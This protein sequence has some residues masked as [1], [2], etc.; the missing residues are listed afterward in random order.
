VPVGSSSATFSILV[1]NVPAT[2]TLDVIAAYDDAVLRAP[3]TI[4]G[5][6]ASLASMTVNV[7]TLTGGQGGVGFVNLTAPAPAGHV[8]V[9]LSTD[10]PS[11]TLPPNV[12]IS[13]GSTNGLFSFGALPVDVVTPV[14]I[15]ATYGASRA[16]AGVTINP[17]TNVWVT[18]LALSPTTVTGGSSSTGTVTINAPA[19]SGG[20]TVQ[21][22]PWSPGHRAR[23]GNR[24][25]RFHDRHLHDWHD[26]RDVDDAGQDMGRSQHVVG[27]GADDHAWSGKRAVALHAVAVAHDRH[28]RQ[29]V[30]GHGD[31]ERSGAIRWLGRHALEQQYRRCDGSGERDGRGGNVESNLTVTTT[32]VS[33]QA[34]ATITGSLGVSRSSTLTINPST[35]TPAAPALVAPADGATVTLPVTLDWSDVAN[36]VS[37]QIQVDDSSAFTS[38]FVVNQTVTPSQ[39]T[40]SSAAAARQHW[41]RVRGTNGAGT[42]GAW[43]AVRTFTTAGGT[44]PPPP[45]PG[46]TRTLTVTASGRSGERITSSPTGIN[47]T[48]GSTGSATFASGTSITLSVSNGRDAVW[49]GACSSGGNKTRTCTFTLNADATVTANVQ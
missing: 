6:A 17:S 2:T 23:D 45:P 11:I 34:L 38:P 12:T 31:A 41:W 22:S 18:S 10:N 20:A 9:D 21:I 1:R 5:T 24:A 40:L 48:V 36:A 35:P 27:S 43:S 30:A 16:T 7:S 15:S 3:L 32:T 13:Q 4:S 42:N 44:P 19:P 33:S 8:L 47:V 37:Y 49:S 28:G 26:Q 39:F 46:T 14:T 25:G 29:F